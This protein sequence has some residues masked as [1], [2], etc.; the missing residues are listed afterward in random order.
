MSSG[1]ESPELTLDKLAEQ[2]TNLAGL[3]SRQG[4]VL[5]KTGEQV[6]EMQIK[7]TKA[8]VDAIE[9]P[10]LRGERS[11]QVQPTV[12]TTDFVT[13]EDIVQLVGE[14]QGQLDILEQRTIRRTVNSGLVA[15][16]AIVAPQLNMDGLE[17][18]PGTFPKTLGGFNALTDADL[19]DLCTFYDLLPPNEEQEQRMN[20]FM[21]GEAETPNLED[22]RIGAKPEDYDQK[23]LDSLFDE[24]A[25]YIGVR[26]RRTEGA[27]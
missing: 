19:V 11:K 24:L 7:G 13:N 3:V 22:L 18:S 25:R 14:L 4:K 6:L 15:Q 8:E 2:V 27:W 9:V 5:S 21:S 1:T 26:S 12:D 10:T 17:P 16:D 23:E 20:E